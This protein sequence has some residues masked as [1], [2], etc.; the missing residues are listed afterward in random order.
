MSAS[1]VYHFCGNS[2][3]LLIAANPTV[4]CPCS[5][6]VLGASSTD[7]LCCEFPVRCLLVLCVVV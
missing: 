7:W 5:V 6:A 3:L 2:S 4:G 1:I